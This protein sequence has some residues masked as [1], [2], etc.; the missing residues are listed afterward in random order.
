L[1]KTKQ[2][3]EVACAYGLFMIFLF[4]VAFS[5]YYGLKTIRLL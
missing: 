2:F 4:S 1:Y 3:M 5:F